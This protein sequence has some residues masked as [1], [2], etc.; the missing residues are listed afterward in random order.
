VQ[1]RHTG[2]GENAF[3]M[4]SYAKGACWIKVMDNFVGR[5]TLK[6]GLQKYC[7]LYAGKNTELN[8]LVNCMNDALREVKGAEAAKD[9]KL[10]KWTNSW[11]KT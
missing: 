3:D 2:D 11:L 1:I 5:D 6:L 4:I 7:Q 9:D 8:D 10:I